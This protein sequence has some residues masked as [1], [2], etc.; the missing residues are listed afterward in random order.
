VRTRTKSEREG[1]WADAYC[2]EGVL[3]LSASEEIAISLM[4]KEKEIG[5]L[6]GRRTINKIMERVLEKRRKTLVKGTDS[7]VAIKEEKTFAAE[8]KSILSEDQGGRKQT[9]S[10]GE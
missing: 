6:R 10:R 4:R 2:R 1:A 9:D 8:R 5:R 7:C 3:L